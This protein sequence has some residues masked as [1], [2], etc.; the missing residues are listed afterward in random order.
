MEPASI[1]GHT[2]IVSMGANQTTNMTKEPTQPITE[3]A[4]FPVYL[5]QPEKIC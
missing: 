5:L 3:E 2:T 4:D 1:E